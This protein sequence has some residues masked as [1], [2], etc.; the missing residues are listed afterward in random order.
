MASQADD[1]LVASKTEGYKPGEKK[2]IDEYAKLGM[3]EIKTS[4]SHSVLYCIR[5]P[6]HVEDQDILAALLDLLQVRKKKNEGLA[7]ESSALNL[8]SQS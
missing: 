8:L 7:T 4:L 3:W 2:T 1:D 6:A 5:I